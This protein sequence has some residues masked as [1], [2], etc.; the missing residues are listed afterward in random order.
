M[1]PK[2]PSHDFLGE[3]LSNN[4]LLPIMLPTRYAPVSLSHINAKIDN[5]RIGEYDVVSPL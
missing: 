1:P 4:F 2:K 5:T 3:I